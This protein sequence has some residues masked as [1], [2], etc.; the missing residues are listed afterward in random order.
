LRITGKPTLGELDNPALPLYRRRTEGLLRKY[1][2]MAMELGHLPSLLG[3]EFF[4]AHVSSYTTHTFEDAVIFVHDVERCLELLPKHWQMVIARLFFQQYSNEE[5]AAL[6]G[7]GLSTF[8]RHRAEAVR[9]ISAIFL[10]RGMLERMPFEEDFENV[11]IEEFDE[12][13]PPKKPVQADHRLPG[14]AQ[15]TGEPGAPSCPPGTRLSVPDIKAVAET[16]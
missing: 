11:E 8:E 15:R 16:A 13:W 1:F 2:R 14:L 6:M 10:K 3:K 7:C 4:R 9:A 12:E 5:A